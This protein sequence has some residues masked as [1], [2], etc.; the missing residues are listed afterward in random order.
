VRDE[1]RGSERY[2]FSLKIQFTLDDG[3]VHAG[4]MENVS[5]SGMLIVSPETI[6]SGKRIR[7]MFN[8]P[9]TDRAVEIVGE[10][11]RTSSVGTFGVAFVSASDEALAFVERI[12]SSVA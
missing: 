3:V 11:V 9:A 8:E 7:I 1:R 5:R 6:R 4:A 2:K 10:V 12:T